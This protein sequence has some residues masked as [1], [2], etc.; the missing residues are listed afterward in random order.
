MKIK[1]VIAAL[2]FT[3]VSCNKDAKNSPTNVETN[4]KKIDSF[5]ID[6]PQAIVA[7]ISGNNI[8]VY[9]MISNDVGVY[10]T[11]TKTL[12]KFNKYGSGFDE[13][14]ASLHPYT[15]NFIADSLI[16]I[17]SNNSVKVYNFNGELKKT[18]KIKNEGTYAPLSNFEIIEDS[19]F[20][21]INKPQ[22]D[23][24]TRDF[25]QQ[26]HKL[27]IKVNINSD[28]KN[29]FGD[30]PLPNSDLNLSNEDFY[31][32]YPFIYFTQLSDDENQYSMINSNDQHLY[33]FD[34]GT[35]TLIKEIKLDLDHYKPLK[36]SFDKKVSGNQMADMMEFYTNSTIIGYYK[37]S[38]YD[39]IVYNEALENDK[40][41]E[42]FKD[43]DMMSPDFES[44]QINM[45]VHVLD[46]DTKKGEDLLIP[47]ALG[48]PVHIYSSNKL[49]FSTP[50]TEEN[51]LNGTTP[52][53]LYSINK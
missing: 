32:P 7:D 47:V 48:Y 46:D 17:S 29:H 9:N 14:M 41:V 33:T 34:I 35:S 27:V 44:P 2:I 15:L 12:N 13:F 42:H 4:F 37:G 36:K 49:L 8:L 5:T 43:N 22:G 50:I 21:A 16:G 25:Y 1:F 39:Y 18:I 40:V 10:N 45:W 53:Y 3:I 31:Y 51:D 11:E 20:V 28:S 52:F 30:F 19:I 38:D 26:K 23:H 24:T 6:I